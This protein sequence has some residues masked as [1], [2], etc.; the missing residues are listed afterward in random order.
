MLKLVSGQRFG[1]HVYVNVYQSTVHGGPSRMLFTLLELTAEK[2]DDH[3]RNK[4]RTQ[5]KELEP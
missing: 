4:L 2:L 1:V 5:R 3:L